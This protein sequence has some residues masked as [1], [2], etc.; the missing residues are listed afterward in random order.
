[1][2][3]LK[4]LLYP[5]EISSFERYSMYN[6]IQIEA[7]KNKS[8][9][10]FHN[11]NGDISIPFQEVQYSDYYINA[12]TTLRSVSKPKT[13]W[14]S[15]SKA[16]RLYMKDYYLPFLHANTNASNPIVYVKKGTT[17]IA[18]Q[19]RGVCDILLLGILHN[20]V[21]KSSIIFKITF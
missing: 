11:S 7:M 5:F 20:R 2:F 15:G 10:R 12:S 4:K 17:G 3:Y 16:F 14:K 8:D 6:P 1:M 18:G 13:I 19:M 9:T 21:I